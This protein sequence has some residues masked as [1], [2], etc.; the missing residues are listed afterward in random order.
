MT[1]SIWTA[2]VA[3]LAVAGPL[4]AQGGGMGGGG[5]MGMGGPG[6]MMGPNVEQLQSL[7]KLDDA[8]LARVRAMVDSFRSETAPQREEAQRRFQEMRAARQGGA[9]EDSLAKLRSNAMA[10]MMD[11]RQRT[12]VLEERIVTVLTPEQQKAFAAWREERRARM[13]ERM[14]QGM[15]G[16]RRP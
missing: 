4:A 7:L 12:D 6:G 11:L 16:G 5:G 1:R 15:G 2:A 14:G 13:Q 3:C 8:Q 10:A 9:S